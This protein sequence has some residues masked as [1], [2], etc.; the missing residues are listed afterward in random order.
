[1][2]C[3]VL[4]VTGSHRVGVSVHTV[5]DWDL[6]LVRVFTSRGRERSPLSL[7]P[8][9][10]TRPGPTRPGTGR[11]SEEDSTDVTGLNPRKD[12]GASCPNR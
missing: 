8:A 4:R 10:P 3:G 1:M 7:G 2:T 11:D 6:D 12:G 9:L 5:G